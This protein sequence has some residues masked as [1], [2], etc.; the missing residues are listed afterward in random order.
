[1]ILGVKVANEF[2]F[3]YFVLGG[4]SNLLVSDA[5]FNGLVIKNSIKKITI[6]ALSGK[7]Q[8]GNIDVRDVLVEVQSGV[9]FNQLVRFALDEGLSGLEC[10]LGIPGTIGGALWINAHFQ[11]ENMFVGDFVVSAEILTTGSEIRRVEKGYFRFQ[12]DKTRLKTT[13]DTVLSV[14]FK[15]KKG[16]KKILWQKAMESLNFRRISQPTLPSAGCV[17]QNIRNADAIR[18]GTPNYTCSAGYLIEQCGLKGKKEGGVAISN[19][20]ANFIVNTGN[21]KA[22][23]VKRLMEVMKQAVFKKFR[24]ILIPEIVFLGDFNNGKI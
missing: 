12:Y 9:P 14:I 3:P 6:L 7:V 15:L 24:L 13:Q 19:Q 17:F 21:G 5:G 22:S 8:K 16:D 1:L 20:H 4:G 18:I 11:K 2:H 10:F 23:E